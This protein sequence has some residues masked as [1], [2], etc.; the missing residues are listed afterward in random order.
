MKNMKSQINMIHIKLRSFYYSLSKVVKQLLL[1]LLIYIIL[2]SSTNSSFL[3]YNDNFQL[4]MY[5]RNESILCFE[6]HVKTFGFFGINFKKDV[7]NSDMIMIELFDKPTYVPSTKSI[8][9]YGISDMW[10]FKETEEKD[11]ID[12]G[13]TDD[14]INTRF[15]MNP[16]TKEKVLYFERHLITGDVFDKPLFV[17]TS[18]DI[19]FIWLNDSL[20]RYHGKN[21]LVTSFTINSKTNDVYF[22]GYDGEIN[23][24]FLIY[25]I[26]GIVNFFV[27]GTL[28]SIAII[29]MRFYKHK[30]TGRYVHYISSS[31]IIIVS[32]ASNLFAIINIS[33]SFLFSIK[34]LLPLHDL[35]GI[36]MFGL[37]LIQAILGI[38]TFILLKRDNH[39]TTIA[40]IVKRFHQINGFSI[41]LI[42]YFNITIGIYN[43]FKAGIYIPIIV[44]I[45]NILI[46]LCFEIYHN[47]YLQ[48]YSVLRTKKLISKLQKKLRIFDSLNQFKQ[49][50]IL[51]STNYMKEM[52]FNTNDSISESIDNN[53]NTEQSEAHESA[54]L[55]NNKIKK[56]NANIYYNSTLNKVIVIFENIICDITEFVILHPGGNFLKEFHEK[57]VTRFLTGCYAY[58]SNFS[59]HSHKTQTIEMVLKSYALALLS[60][61]YDLVYY[62]NKPCYNTQLFNEN[63]NFI[64]LN[65]FFKL[66]NKFL[67]AKNTYCFEFQPCNKNYSFKL[68]NYGIEFIGMHWSIS[69]I[70]DNKTRIYSVCY[71]MHPLIKYCHLELINFMYNQYITELNECN[72]KNIDEIIIEDKNDNQNK[73]LSNSSSHNS[74]NLSNK[75]NISNINKTNNTSSNFKYKKVDSGYKRVISNLYLSLTDEKHFSPYLNIYARVYLEDAAVEKYNKLEHNSKYKA[76]KELQVTEIEAK[77]SNDK[78]NNNNIDLIKKVYPNVNKFYNNYL[79]YELKSGSFPSLLYLNN[80]KQLEDY[81][82]RGPFDKNLLDIVTDLSGTFILFSGGTGSLAFLDLVALLI[83]YVNYLLNEEEYS[84]YKNEDFSYIKNDFKIVYFA[85]YS[86][87]DYGLL[88]DLCSK[89]NDLSILL[90]K[91]LGKNIFKY[92]PR[93]SDKDNYKWNKDFIEREFRNI[94]IILNSSLKNKFSSLPSNSRISD[95]EENEFNI[96]VCGTISMQESLQDCFKQLYINDKKI[97]YM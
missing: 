61:P 15:F 41:I 83:R 49:K 74:N 3:K 20:A 51:M 86:S 45:I 75:S 55:L 52:N 7:H 59:H 40:L 47:Y 42:A 48:S 22:Y 73:S 36:M 39:I 24:H 2:P 38:A 10:S 65:H 87:K 11:D 82:I 78:N 94:D 77:T 53:H 18:T 9:Y 31:T 28:S 71:I 27:W 19:A 33:H 68:V 13:G 95:N 50:N 44:A 67:V 35:L 81:V 29:S 34:K 1:V 80:N 5:L 54:E 84:I 85:S 23:S 89:L 16:E 69:S 4:N 79:S 64:Y 21:L 62:M 14:I 93:Y 37:L 96:L 70:N 90:E 60:T 32:L 76:L 92:V 72:T 26:H 25:K 46:I 58:N 57:D 43:Y 12:L 30:K 63:E 88:T 91:K 17:D 56:A 8:S 97:H 6:L 66:N